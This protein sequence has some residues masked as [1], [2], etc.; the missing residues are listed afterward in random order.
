M[1][2]S[3][4]AVQKLAEEWRRAGEMIGLVPTMGALHEGH[5]SLVRRARRN[6]SKVIVSIF[7]NPTQFGPREDLARYPRPFRKDATLLRRE[8]CD[9][10]FAPA[11]RDMYPLGYDTYVVPGRIADVLEGARRPGHFRGVATVCL[12]LFSICKPHAAYFGRKDYQQTCVIGQLISDLDLDLTLKVLPTVRDKDGLALSSRN[13]YLSPRAREIALNISRVLRDTAATLKHDK[14]SLKTA[15]R[16]GRA[17]LRRVTGLTLD[18]FDVRETDTLQEVT[19]HSKRVVLL[20]AARVGKTRL[21]DNLLVR[22]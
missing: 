7:V 17:A 4:A 2:K 21:I 1:L 18:Y 22:L 16:T 5:L 3:P 13:V 11:A 14:V 12:K 8:R 19:R 9:M 10:L 20:A 6:C 15:E